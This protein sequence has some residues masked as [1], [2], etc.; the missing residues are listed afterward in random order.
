M[1]FFRLLMRYNGDISARRHTA[2]LEVLSFSVDNGFLF[3]DFLFL[4]FFFGFNQ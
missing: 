4:V 3:F 2:T 1:F